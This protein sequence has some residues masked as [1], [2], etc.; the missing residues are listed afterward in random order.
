MRRETGS[1]WT[2]EKGKMRRERERDGFTHCKSVFFAFIF[3]LHLPRHIVMLVV[4]VAGLYF[5]WL[6]L[7]E[8]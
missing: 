4:R 6:G 3:F 7:E 1:A 2:I 5:V 8:L